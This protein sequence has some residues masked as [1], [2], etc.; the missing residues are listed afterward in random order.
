M[1]NRDRKMRSRWWCVTQFTDDYRW[2]KLVD[3]GHCRFV[4]WGKETCPTTGRKHDQAFVYLT[5]ASG[6]VKNVSKLV[7]GKNHVEPMMGN[8]R[9]NKEYCAKE[10]VYT[11][12]GEKPS[13]GAR[14]DL[15]VLKEKIEEGTSVE[16][17]LMDDPLLF[18]QYGRTLTKIEE[19]VNRKIHREWMTKGIWIHGPTGTG[20][21][22]RAFQD[23]SPE[24]HY[25]FRANDRGWWEDYTGQETVIIDD[26][27]GEIQYAELLRIVDKYPMT[28]PRRGRSGVPLLAKTVIITSSKRPE[29]VYTNLSAKDSLDQ[30]R[31]RF[32]IVGTEVLT[33]KWSEGNT[34]PPTVEPEGT[35]ALNAPRSSGPRCITLML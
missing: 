35:S 29:D 32:E 4:A 8:V 5:N 30:L 11:E 25:V 20:K 27:R 2:E 24:T 6:S 33:Q 3:G 10:G 34:G 19:V 13:Q 31:R 7:G 15:I 14:E 22:E 12:Y 26:F 28:M 18:H 9:Q 16:D 23:Y 21:T 17:L 1:G